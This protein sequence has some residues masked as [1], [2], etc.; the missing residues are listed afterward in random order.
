MN[1]ISSTEVNQPIDVVIAWIDGDDPRLSEKLNGYLNKPSKRLAPG[2]QPTR[3]ASTNEIRYCVLSIFKFAPFVRNVFIVT[4]GQDPNIYDEVKAYFP[5]RLNSIRI[6]DH[7]EIFRGY[8]EYLPSFSSTSIESMIWR[9]NGLSD[10]FVYFNDD[11][12]LIREVKPEDW[13]INNRPVLRGKWRLAPIKKMGTDF[14]KILLF[15]H[16]LK[17]KNYQ[18]RLSFYIRQWKAAVKLGV[19]M[20][21]FFHCHTPHVLNRTTLGNYFKENDELLRKNISYRFRSKDQFITIALANHLEILSGNKNFA[22]LNLGY[23]VPSY[24]SKRRL[25]KKIRRCETNSQIK[26]VCVQS[27][28]TASEKDQDKIFTLLD[29]FIVLQKTHN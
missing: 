14:L 20:R 29:K 2:A 27:L 22:K 11:V 17:R 16:L 7:K 5:E 6:V 23:L 10:N 13:V 21:Y 28:D 12:F 9:I 18:P 25:N 26:S 1:E 3:F 4:D 15:R 24:Y 19:K 8:E